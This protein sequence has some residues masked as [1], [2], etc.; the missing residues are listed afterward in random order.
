MQPYLVPSTVQQFACLFISSGFG[1]GRAYLIMVPL[2]DCGS[3]TWE[4]RG[5]QSFIQVAG[6]ENNTEWA[7]QLLSRC[8]RWQQPIGSDIRLKSKL[9]YQ[10]CY[11]GTVELSF[12]LDPFYQ[13]KAALESWKT[14]NVLSSSGLSHGFVG[15][16]IPFRTFHSFVEQSKPLG[17]DYSF[18]I[19][20]F[21][22]IARDF[23][24]TVWWFKWS[25]ETAKCTK[26]SRPSGRFWPFIIA[27][28]IILLITWCKPCSD[29]LHRP[30][31][32]H[33]EKLTAGACYVSL[34]WRQAR[35]QSG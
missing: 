5:Y 22:F 21:Y 2:L 27:Y 18:V 30:T 23:D 8:P 1:N 11:N 20:Y 7:R 14:N 33:H 9:E 31:D 19:S 12:E 10:K 13:S 15:Q 24:A 6:P 25:A 4:G 26:H 35:G 3:S 28:L 32:A 34:E 29:C 16:M 17:L